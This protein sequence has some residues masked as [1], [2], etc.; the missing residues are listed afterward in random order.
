MSGNS[1]Q[2]SFP[3]PP[4]MP[5]T[6]PA[7]SPTQETSAP[8]QQAPMTPQ[9]QTEQLNAA[10]KDDKVLKM[11]TFSLQKYLKE[12]DFAAE[13]LERGGLESLCEIIKKAN[14][15][16]LAYALNSFDSLLE[17]ETGW[18]S[19][20]ED[21]VVDIARI[22]VKEALVTIVR[23]A[24]AILIKIVTFNAHQ[25]RSFPAPNATTTASATNNKPTASSGSNKQQQQQQQDTA[26]SDA[27]AS[28]TSLLSFGYPTLQKA[29]ERV[30]KLLPT[31]VQRLQ[32]QDY[33]LC[34]NSL[35]LLTAMIKMVTDEYRSKL[36]ESLEAYDLKKYIVRLMN[37]SPSEELRTQLL[38]YQTVMGQ[39]F[40]M[41]RKTHVSLKN[42]EDAQMLN[43]IWEAA[44]VDDI[45]IPGARK[46]K[47]LGFSSENPQ[48][49]FVRT[50]QFGLQRL[51]GLVMSNPDLF[52]KTIME[53]IHR[54]ENKRC[55]YAKTCCECTELLFSQW[56]INTGYIAAEFEPI[57]LYLDRVQATT[58]RLFFRLFQDMGA[59]IADFSKVSALVRSQLRAV[60][61]TEGVKDMNEFERVMDGTPYQT[62][63]NRRLKELEWADDLLGR[64]AIKHLR[65]RLNKQSYE[66]IK[67]Q[68][69]QCLVRGAWFPAPSS[70]LTRSGSMAMPNSNISMQELIGGTSSSSSSGVKRWRYY[71]LSPSKKALLFGDFAEVHTAVI[72]DYDALPNKI[73]L[74][75]VADIRATRKPSTTTA[76]AASSMFPAPPSS[77]A[78]PLH[79][80]HQLHS[81]SMDPTSPG[82]AL[83]VSGSDALLGTSPT[84]TSYSSSA[85]LSFG[86]Y[87]SSN[88][89]LAEFKCATS[90]QLSEWKDGFSMLLDKG[91]T[92]KE[93]AEYLHSLTEIGVKVKLLQIAGDRVEVPHGTLDVPPL[94]AGGTSR[95]YYDA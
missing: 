59:T 37:S 13:F 7:Q 14:G 39:N 71:K 38:E 52:S 95:F 77:T 43:D 8:Q 63:R 9:A 57:L 15:N 44:K 19:L 89:L 61:K 85:V 21:F 54:P 80:H 91:I 5:A 70:S 72:D 88:R 47:K 40:S 58:V 75:N 53:Q 82:G 73:E 27:A 22:V 60:L 34:L 41:R 25:R 81:H 18:K 10:T 51:H 68:R 23:P 24:T 29:I 94:P 16:T 26:K 50:G 66:F 20:D 35:A 90:E 11:A 33:T 42:P 84:A 69:I 46:W 6:L 67:K 62:I 28:A 87:T 32:S 3:S 92:S 74:A 49:Q 36:P 30:P 56:N 12:P 2:T 45:Q 55:P 4:P 48:R 86:L 78:S 65:A 31:L 93:T 83:P 64:D 1:S 76:A 79:H 17:H